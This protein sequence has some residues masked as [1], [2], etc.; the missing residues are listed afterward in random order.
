MHQKGGEFD[1][2]SEMVLP[3]SQFKFLQFLTPK[4][5]IFFVSHLILAT[6]I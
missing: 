4:F 5:F 1:I 3:K 6:L 2:V